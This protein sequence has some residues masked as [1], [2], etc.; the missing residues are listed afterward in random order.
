MTKQPRAIRVVCFIGFAE[1]A[2]I[3]ALAALLLWWEKDSL[4]GKPSVVRVEPRPLQQ[5]L[6]RMIGVFWA[7]LV[8]WWSTM[9]IAMIGTWRMR[10][11]GPILFA[12]LVAVTWLFWFKAG[13]AGV[14]WIDTIM[15]AVALFY[16]RDMTWKG[17][18]GPA[19]VPEAVEQGVE[20]DEA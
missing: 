18:R 13:L 2:A 5:A 16:L 4:F 6:S 9:L 14:P 8:G 3:L 11:W 15:A 12:A 19:G 1:L 7:L 10:K 20:A 17:K